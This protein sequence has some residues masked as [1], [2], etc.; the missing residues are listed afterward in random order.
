M[1]Y[2]FSEQN[3]FIFLIQ[4]FFLLGLARLLGE[5]F[6]KWKQPSL[7]AEIIVG[8]M[9]GPTVFGRLFP[10]LYKIIFPLD[11]TQQNMLETVAW[12]GL[13]F[14]LLETGLKM[15]FSSAWRHRGRALMIAITDIIVPMLI[16]FS[17]TLLLP[18]KYL[19]NPQQRLTFALFMATAMTISAMPI[20][21]R[22]LNDLNLIK[23]DI[24]YLI[25][26][27]LS[28]NEVIGWLI[29]TLILGLFIH[30]EAQVSRVLFIFLVSIGFIIFCLSA[31]KRLANLIISKIKD[32]HMP[33]PA[34]SL[35][36]ICLLGFLCG[37]I[38]QKFG[39][40]ALLGFFIAGIMAG[41]AEAL[42]ERTRQVISQMVYAI[43]VPL[44]FV[45]IGLRIDFL[46]NFNVFLVLFVT[47][48]GIFGKFIGAWLGVTFTEISRVN[49][50]P[51][52]I[53]HI[54]G[55]SMEIVLGMLALRYNLISESIFVAIIFGAVT[56]SLILGPWLRYSITRR[57][58]ISILEFF[59]RREIIAELKTID[60]ED[61]IDELCRVASEQVGMPPA[62][63]LCSLVLD[64]EK[65]MG[66]AI[67]ESVALPH[68][69]IPNLIKSVIV[70]GRSIAGIDWNS[71]DGKPAHF[72]FLIVT[73]KEDD[74]AQVQILRIISRIMSK[75]NTRIRIMSAKDA[76]E[77]WDILAQ[78]FT[79]QHIV[80]K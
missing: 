77:I 26:S 59:S 62:D 33:E 36:F 38:F 52:A 10:N 28:V 67:E 56:S 69:R 14:L 18:A 13:L 66:T 21:T 74:E 48:I 6:R 58:E 12:L 23:T 68:A 72:I 15:D 70:F 79:Q 27:A 11:I 41:E 46:K 2:Y 17:L 53:A 37:A 34:A 1:P 80:R 78:E 25:M 4:L 19:V 32:Y 3:I 9:L 57:K 40:H 7:T 5:F 8:V 45:G 47:F 73:P 42:P 50:L 60:R 39:I 16:G 20:T 61:V 44:F 51:I 76:Q 71:P 43:F 24:G 35:T 49:R 30:I 22:V 63:T 54:P 55:G 65:L 64:R 75:E 31:G 29:F